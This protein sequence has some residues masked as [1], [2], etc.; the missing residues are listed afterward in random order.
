MGKFFA[1]INTGVDGNLEDPN[2]YKK[3]ASLERHNQLAFQNDSLHLTRLQ[4]NTWK[5]LLVGVGKDEQQFCRKSHISPASGFQ[6]GKS[7]RALN[8]VPL[9]RLGEPRITHAIIEAKTFGGDED[10]CR[11]HSA[12]DDRESDFGSDLSFVADKYWTATI[13]SRGSEE[14]ELSAAVHICE[15]VQPCLACIHHGSA[16]GTT[17]FKL[18]LSQKVLPI[19]MSQQFR[20]QRNNL[21]KDLYVQGRRICSLFFYIQAPLRDTAM[22][23]MIS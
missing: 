17:S 21:R 13:S 12:E 8:P 2:Y 20:S 14:A 15:H 6:F 16:S 19:G 4:S 11:L 9:V 18:E 1:S 22:S 5:A 3:A 7:T 10:Y 23:F